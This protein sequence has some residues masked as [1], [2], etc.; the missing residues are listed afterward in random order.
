MTF[1]DGAT[2]R[3]R[4]AA[5]ELHS[6][7]R[8]AARLLRLFVWLLV[9]L[10]IIS[11]ASSPF[12]QRRRPL[13][14][15]A[16]RDYFAGKF[17]LIPRDDRP[18]SVQQP[19]MM[20][21]V[22]DHDLVVAPAGAMSDAGKLIE[23]AR[24]IDYA[25]V[26]GVIVSLDA[27]AGGAENTTQ[28]F[29]ITK[30]VRAQRQ[31]LP[32]YAFTTDSSDRLVQA[33]LSLIEESALDFLLI[34]GETK[35][36]PSVSREARG[37]LTNEIAA[38]GLNDRVA[39]EP[40]AD[41]ATMTLLSRLL[42]RR[43]GFSPKILP[44]FSSDEGRNAA[45]RGSLLHRKV[46]AAIKTIDGRELSQTNNSARSVDVLLFVHAPQTPDRN[47]AA[48]I[49]TIA[50]TID[51]SVAVALADL[52]ETKA[53]KEAVMAELRRR[54]LLGKLIAYASS[55]PGDDSTDAINRA[56]T[57]ASAFLTA[58]RFLRDDLARVRRFDRA[59]FD[60]L[61]SGYL[62]DWAYALIVR[63]E[64]DAFVREQ[65]K[66]DPNR[67]GANADRAAAF[68]FEQIRP[69]AEQLFN[70]Q[71]KR[72]IHAILLS[73]GERVQF[74]ISMLQRLQ[75]RLAAQNASE[76]DIRQSVYV[77]QINL[78]LLP[79]SLAR[80]RWFLEN[81]DVD[82]RIAQ[83]F[84]ATDWGRFKTGVEEIEVSVKILSQPGAQEGYT[85][86]SARRKGLRRVAIT[87]A[88]NQ[89]VFYALSKLEMLGAEG[90]LAQDFQTA[91]SPSFARRGIIESFNDTPWSHRDRLEMLR[92]LGRARMNRYIYAPKD[93]P[94]R[95]ENYPGSEPEQ[96][97]QLLRVAEENFVQIVYAVGPGLP[98][99][100][101]SDEDAAA[102]IS[103][104]DRMIALGVR[105]FALRFSDV[106]ENL[107]NG[108]DRARFKTAASAHAH[109]I[110]RVY[111][112]L[113][114][115]GNDFEL[116]VMPK[117]DLNAGGN[118]DYLKELGSAIPPEVAIFQN[119]SEP[120]SSEH[121]NPQARTNRR[122]IILDNFPANDEKPWRLFLGAKR[123]AQPTLDQDA[124]GF[125][126]H[127]MS[128]ARA[129]M[130]S[131]ATAAEYAWNPRG[132]DP[133]ASLDRAL[134]LL[135]DERA[136]KAVRVWAQNYGDY[137]H[138]IF[139]PLFQKQTSEINV[140]LMEQKLAELQ[141]AVETIGVTLE[142]GLLRGELAQFVARTRS[143][144]EKWKMKK[145]TEP[146]EN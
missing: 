51:K 106:A 119:G 115:S 88:S 10:L 142:Q 127:P 34:A 143:A 63:P 46:S 40:D 39:M 54:K 57:H 5:K 3:H 129:S 44:V 141:D 96:F 49:E 35:R 145:G 14:R 82:D 1:E 68:A 108:E 83:R 109:L 99:R 62:R 93:D 134:N 75:V 91:E 50:Q 45:I 72:N 47:R 38:Q 132:Y 20:A 121:T 146:P 32:I 23:W 28:R 116:S 124:I 33:A 110:N 122:P 85:I 22:A 31:G 92:F 97:N 6:P 76:A 25:D 69:I 98:F 48:F 4:R 137:R 135:Y 125:I 102:L 139:E 128:Q 133:Q 16:A 131:L 78:P 144:L 114:Q 70:E 80:A 65:L 86:S 8:R 53:S 100:Y 66:S 71:F 12:A 29:G 118:G 17:V 103:K 79:Q 126:A 36:D 105:G 56:V 117:A 24:N 19:R 113:K 84:V 104:L 41:A 89:G 90:R 43:F 37:K 7:M 15:P 27:I 55:E 130:L 42:N 95:M 74:E 52:S 87:A 30:W 67:L 107:R 11:S 13:L 138:D 2:E 60:L 64:L 26:D 77:P 18:S 59:H 21:R 81:E 140:A 120:S 73:T 123:G 58:V 112:H 136:R 9:P 94:L 111:S 61:F 101:S